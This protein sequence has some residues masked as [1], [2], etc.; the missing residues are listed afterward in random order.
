M[1]NTFT[2]RDTLK[3]KLLA[4]L[5]NATTADQIVKLSRTIEKANLDDDADLETALDTKVSA[6]AGTATTEDIEKLAFGVKKLRTSETATDPVSSMIPEGSSNLYVTDSRVRSSF[7]AAG[8]LS[9]DSGTGVLSYTALPDALTVYPTVADL[10][11]SGVSAGAKGIVEENKKLYIFTGASWVGVGLVDQKPSFTTTPDGSYSLSP[12]ADTVITLNATDPQGDPITFSHVVSAGSLGGSTVSQSGNVFTITGSS[13]TNDTAPFT[14]T[15]R[16]SDGTNITDTTSEF[17]V[18]FGIVDWNNLT[19]SSIVKEGYSSYQLMGAG[20]AIDDTYYAIS[21]GDSTGMGYSNLAGKVEIYNIS[22]DSLFRTLTLGAGRGDRI[23]L[24]GSGK[25]AISDNRNNGDMVIHDIA[26]N[27]NT[28]IS[29]AGVYYDSTWHR[30][31]G[32]EFK[33]KWFA[34]MDRTGDTSGASP[35]AK[36]FIYDTEGA[37]PTVP[38]HE[39]TEA[40]I[41]GQVSSGNFGASP[42]LLTEGAG[43]G[44]ISIDATN[45]ILWVSFPKMLGTETSVGSGSGVGD[46]QAGFVIPIDMNTGN[47]IIDKVIPNGQLREGVAYIQSQLPNPGDVPIWYPGGNPV[48]RRTARQTYWGENLSAT[49][50]HVAIG[51][52]TQYTNEW[53]SASGRGA[54]WVYNVSGPSPLLE[55]IIYANAESADF[56]Y[57]RTS[58]AGTGGN[59]VLLNTKVD[60]IGGRSA[61]ASN[62]HSGNDIFL[63]DTQLFIGSTRSGPAGI[64][65]S[66]SQ[67]NEG[68]VFVVNLSDWSV[69]HEINNPNF[70]GESNRSMFGGSIAVHGNKLLVGEAWRGQN[71]NG[72][73]Q[74]I[75]AS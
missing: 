45:D 37:N 17:T 13:D 22:D 21:E 25:L 75:T 74:L 43:G 48:N 31:E 32:F 8:D 29:T 14:L 26:T 9:Y 64:S 3:T 24:N 65:S 54:I 36:I 57:Y 10:P 33:G 12:G 60:Y 62:S 30:I 23:A 2:A 11:A 50:T 19:L 53:A 42:D 5:G 67:S 63:T 38:L 41:V 4:A 40:Y 71:N 6:M 20:T 15:F 58:A 18:T 49:S 55:A 69:A 68:A 70:T 7:S 27:S 59:T 44:E 46:R 34:W 39:V 16:A 35:R 66:S 72:G 28:T 73:A 52:P 51:A 1:A 47:I 61:D 56:D